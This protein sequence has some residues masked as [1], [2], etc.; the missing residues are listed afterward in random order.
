MVKVKHDAGHS[1]FSDIRSILRFARLSQLPGFMRR[2][3]GLRAVRREEFL[4]VLAPEER[5]RLRSIA[6]AVRGP[7]CRPAVFVHGVLPRSGTNFVADALALHP[8]LHQNPGRLWEFPLLYVA[9][10]AEA[11][12]REFLFMFKENAEVLGRHDMLA[13]LASG[14]MRALQEQTGEK[15]M[16]FKAPHVQNIGLFADV[17]PRDVLVL[18]LRDGRDVI[19]SSEG[20]FGGR[21]LVRKDFGA[22][23]HEWREGCEAIMSFAPGGENAYP[24]AKVL[25]YEDLVRDPEGSMRDLLA[26]ARLDPDRYDFE[27]LKRLPVRGSS[28]AAAASG[29]TPQEKAADFNPL[30]RWRGWPAPKKA[31]FK[32]IAGGALK[33]A[34]YEKDDAW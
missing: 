8:D 1:S 21:G 15:R 19:Q 7:G 22:L 23:A 29:W 5:A 16:L 20:T 4:P 6:D 27:A 17:F 14:W 11:L 13:Y 30:G 2:A 25:W 18:V 28:T 9:G 32:S 24:G 34:G 26:H 10:G 33:R 31:R 3:V 12:Q